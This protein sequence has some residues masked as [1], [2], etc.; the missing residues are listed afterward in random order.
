MSELIAIEEHRGTESAPRQPAQAPLNLADLTSGILDTVEDAFF[1][2]D[3]EWRFLY[4]NRWACKLG[5]KPAEEMIGR[6]ITSL[7]PG[8]ESM[9]AYKAIRDAI[10][11][12]RAGVAVDAMMMG[13]EKTWRELSVQI[14][15]SN[16]LCVSRDVT[17]REK[18]RSEIEDRNVRM[19]TFVN[20]IPDMAWIKD[21]QSKFIVAN[22]AFCTAVGM[23]HD[24]LVNNTCDVCFGELATKFKADDRAVMAGGVQKRIEE[25]IIDAKKNVVWL[26]TIKS[27]LR[28]AEGKIVGTVGIA[29][30]I[31]E[32]KRL[33]DALNTTSRLAGMADVAISVLHNVG[34]ALNSVNIS[35]S[36]MSEK[37]QSSH[38]KILGKV[39]E[40]LIAHRDDLPQFISEDSAG[41]KLVPT[42]ITLS[43]SIMRERDE[44]IKEMKAVRNHLE[45]IMHTISLQQEHTRVT[46]VVEKCA[47]DQVVNEG[48]AFVLTTCKEKGIQVATEV[49]EMLDITLDRHQI[50]QIMASL[51]MNAVDAVETAENKVIRIVGKRYGDD[52]FCIQVADN[53]VGIS[54]EDRGSI[55]S[56]GF[57]T[58][59]NRRGFSLHNA[60]NLVKTMGGM[61]TFLSE[62]KGCGTVFSLQLP[63]SGK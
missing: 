33:N 26:E 8:F 12:G 7:F 50:V 35:T 6:T 56:Y 25:S 31:T 36:V 13:E 52:Y 14:F 18:V 22:K 44:M 2:L 37:L 61:L 28:D 23:E 27:P 17:Q 59:V 16:L 21:S 49:D 10:I 24:F 4:V 5:Q 51:L 63:I 30:D 29:R 15:G 62:G 43:S 54:Q 55:F 53:G 45:Q 57:T 11:D 40:M 41:K 1:V 39:L 34:N 32:R 19:E 47:L 60:S 3:R 42:L 46:S 48:L 9:N 20:N 38:M 58:K